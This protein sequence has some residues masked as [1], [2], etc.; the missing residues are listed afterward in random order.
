MFCQQIALNNLMRKWNVLR[1]NIFVYQL[2][3]EKFVPT[4]YWKL[5]TKKVSIKNEVQVRNSMD[6]KVAFFCK[7]SLDRMNGFL[8]M[9]E[10]KPL[11]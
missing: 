11:K 5:V 10:S 2:F 4:Y 8:Q 3:V 9:L 1:R 7:I 6:N